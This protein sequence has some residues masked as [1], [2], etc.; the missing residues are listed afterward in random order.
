[1]I[2]GTH[3]FIC[4]PGVAHEVHAGIP[5]AQLLEPGESGHYEHIEQPDEFA[6][7]VR[8]S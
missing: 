7:I 4:P 1:M 6:A 8:T 2:V 5:D 3:D